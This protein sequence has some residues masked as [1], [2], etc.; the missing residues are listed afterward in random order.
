MKLQAWQP[1]PDPLGQEIKALVKPAGARETGAYA[2]LVKLGLTHCQPLTSET[3][4]A[5]GEE[6]KK[7]ELAGPRVSEIKAI[8]SVA[9]VARRFTTAGLGIRQALKQA[10]ATSL[11]TPSSGP[12]A[13]RATRAR[14]QIT[15]AAEWLICLM[16]VQAKHAVDCGLFRVCYHRPAAPP[17]AGVTAS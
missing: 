10:R 3:V 6:L 13:N 2:R 16:T 4:A 11:R 5:F 15:R 17:K 12:P 9:E 1:E 7:A 8:L 14:S